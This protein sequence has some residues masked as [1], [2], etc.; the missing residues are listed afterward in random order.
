MNFRHR[1]ALFLIVTL[2]TVQALTAA[3][4]YAYLRENLIDRG[5]RE[6][7][8]AMSVFVK[9]LDFLS[10]RASDGVRVLSLD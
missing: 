3:V 8:T 10:E 2:V 6:L 5:R 1:L 4:A 7:A 9:Q